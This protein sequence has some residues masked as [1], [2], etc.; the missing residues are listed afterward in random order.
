MRV[1]S[2]DGSKLYIYM[3]GGQID[4]SQ[5][6]ANERQHIILVY[7][8]HNLS[9]LESSFSL[10][11]NPTTGVSYIES[12]SGASITSIELHCATGKLVRINGD[13]LTSIDGGSYP[14]GT[15]VVV[16]QDSDGM[17]DQKLLI[18]E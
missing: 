4:L 9:Q 14:T 10:F 17:R 8:E 13:N 16:M 12:K 2:I 6:P 11:P 15:Y 5:L 7:P 18:V 3:N 1:T